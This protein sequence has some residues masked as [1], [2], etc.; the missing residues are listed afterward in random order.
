MFTT[1]FSFKEEGE[2]L[3]HI[4]VEDDAEADIYSKFETACDYIG[5]EK[6]NLNMLSLGILSNCF[7]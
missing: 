1:F 3:V 7:I 2:F 6:V 5:K 4:P